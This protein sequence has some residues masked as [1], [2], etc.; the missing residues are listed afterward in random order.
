MEYEVDG[1]V[2]RSDSYYEGEIDFPLYPDPEGESSNDEG[3]TPE[4]S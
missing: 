2:R 4:E 1:K 3:A